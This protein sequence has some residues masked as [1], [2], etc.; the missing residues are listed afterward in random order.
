MDKPL[1]DHEKTRL[2]K[3]AREALEAT[4]QR[5]PLPQLDSDTLTPQM[6]EVG[7][8]FVTLSCSGRLRGCIGAIK[9][10]LPLALDIQI[11][12]QAAARDDYRFTPVRLEELPQ[13]EIEISVL[14]TPQSLMYKNSQDLLKKLEPGVDG[15]ILIHGAHRGTFL[16]QVWERVQG[17]EQFLDLLCQKASLPLNAW[18]DLPVE[19]LTYQV[20]SFGEGPS[21]ESTIKQDRS[22]RSAAGPRKKPSTHT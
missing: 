11:H 14:N 18:R 4:V 19:I 1:T 3:I 20:E 8:S 12:T 5:S 17:P 10:E 15:V 16:P 9:H 6:R 13:I 22:V 21:V 2:L 7:A